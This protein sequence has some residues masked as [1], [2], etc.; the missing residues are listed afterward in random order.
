VPFGDGRIVR[1]FVTS[2]FL[3]LT[4]IG[5]A[6]DQGGHRTNQVVAATQP[7]DQSTFGRADVTCKAAYYRKVQEGQLVPVAEAQ[8]MKNLGVDGIVLQIVEPAQFRG[9]VVAFHFDFPE[10]WDHW[11]L[12]DFLYRGQIHTGYVGSL[13]FMCDPGCFVPVTEPLPFASL[14]RLKPLLRHRVWGNRF[15]AAVKEQFGENVLFDAL[16]SFLTD[17]NRSPNKYADQKAAAGLLVRF[18]PACKVSVERAVS[19]TL[20]TWDES[21]PQWPLYLWR[22]FDHAKLLSAIAEVKKGNL[23]EAEREKIEAWQYWLS[24]S[25]KDL[26]N[27]ATK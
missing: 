23:S 15:A 7:W 26:E 10:N 1:K 6:A 12:P 3:G 20:S 11:Y 24:G 5:Q 27:S 18:Q 2:I 13:A 22:S 19:E 25:E 14:E 4:A 16:Y 8:S 9:K 21:V 17:T